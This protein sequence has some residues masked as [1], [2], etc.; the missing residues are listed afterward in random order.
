[1]KLERLAAFADGDIGG[2]PAGVALM[3]SWPSPEDMMATAANVG[4]SETVFAVPLSPGRWRVR[5]FA[6]EMEVSFCGHATIALGAV[7]ADRV[8]EGSFS[9]DLNDGSI[10]VSATRA[11][12]GLRVELNSPPTRSEPASDD[13]VEAALKLFGYDVEDLNI[14]IPPAVA[15]AGA[16]HLILCLT[17]RESLRSMNYDLRAGAALMRIHGLTT[18]ALVVPRFPRHFDVR[19]AFAAGGVL[20]DPATGAAAAA[21]SGYLR[22]I[23]W[24]HEGR[25]DISQGEDMGA[26]SRIVAE[27]PAERGSS[28]RVSGTVRRLS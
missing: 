18:I 1:M 23:D 28:I 19:N 10:M 13:L 24:P 25:I 4:Y 8:G 20:E 21:L 11:S 12:G 3:E 14:S 22:D 5:Y 27:I 6:P 2:N 7:L 9:L 17:S 16:D 15:H 26:P